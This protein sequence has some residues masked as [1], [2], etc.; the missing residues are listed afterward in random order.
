[1]N[2]E[3]EW[4]SIPAYAAR[5][6]RLAVLCCLF[7]TRST[8]R[9]M[10]NYDRF[11]RAIRRL[12]VPLYTVECRYGNDPFMVPLDGTVLRR[13]AKTVGWHKERLL[14]ILERSVPA[15]YTKLAWLDADLLFSDHGWA[16]ETERLLDDVNV[17]QPFEYARWLDQND[18]GWPERQDQ[19]CQPFPGLIAY[20]HQHGPHAGIFT[21][22]HP[23]FAWAMRRECWHAVDGLC[24]RLITMEGDVV[25]AGAFV[26]FGGTGPPF[27]R[28][29]NE[30]PSVQAWYK[31]AAR[32]VDRTVDF[33]KGTVSHLWHGYRNNRQYLELP[34]QLFDIGRNLDDL[35]VDDP[36]DPLNQ[37]RITAD[38]RAVAVYEN[39]FKIRNQ[40]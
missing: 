37:P 10:Q 33:V 18:V 36:A 23:G 14:N 3:P 20:A 26:G 15:R 27:L 16:Y 39:Y 28:H 11:A 32:V 8:P 7:T 38:P 25:M 35:V 2:A 19:E 4:L 34:Q 30:V 22:A 24:D 17:V 40:D 31:R 6:A 9:I 1:M 29:V 12:G 13:T 21:D 5:Q